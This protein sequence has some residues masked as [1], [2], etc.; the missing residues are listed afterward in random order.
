MRGRMHLLGKRKLLLASI[1]AVFCSPAF[2]VTNFT[3]N[4]TI[5]G[6]G[7]SA[8][9]TTGT[10]TVTVTLNDSLATPTS[11]AQLLSDLAFSVS[12]GQTLAN[13]V[14]VTGNAPLGFITLTDGAATQTAPAGTTNPWTL[15]NTTLNGGAGYLFTGLNGQ[16]QNSTLIIGPVSS[17]Y[18]EPSKCPD[19]LA[20]STFNPYINQTA[21]FTLTIP[22]VTTDSTISNVGFSYGTSAEITTIPIPAAAWL[23][24]SGLLGLIGIARRKQIAPAAMPAVAA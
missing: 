12:G 8:T 24:V 2:A 18:C 13:S 3:V 14:D 22:G 6:L 7:G 23:F 17:T 21:T 11:L 19:G 5:T 1:A 16:P 20:N 10:N 15:S 9:F 4:D